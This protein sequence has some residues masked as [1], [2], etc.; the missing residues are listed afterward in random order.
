MSTH[1]GEIL[2]NLKEFNSNNVSFL[3]YIFRWIPILYAAWI[4]YDLD[5]GEKG[6]RKHA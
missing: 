1:F 5:T 6:G 2:N 4:F 3:P